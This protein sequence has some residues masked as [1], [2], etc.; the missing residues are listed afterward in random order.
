[1]SCEAK[2]YAGAMAAQELRWLTYLLTDLGEQPHSPPILYQRGLLRLAYVATRANTA[3]VFTKELPPGDYQ[4]FSTV[5]G[6]LALL[7]STGLV[8]P[9]F[10]PNLPMGG[11]APS[12]VSHVDPLPGTVP[13]EV[14]LDSGAARGAASGGAASGGAASRVAEPAGAGPEG[15]ESEGADLGG[16]EPGGAESKSAESRG[17]E[18]RGTTSSG[19]PLGAWPQLSP[20]PEPL[21]AQH[22]REWFAQ[23]TRLRSGAAGAGDSAI[24]GTGAGGT[25]ATSLGGAGVLVGA[26]GPRG[27]GAAGSGGLGA[28]GAGGAAG[29]CP[30]CYS[31]NR[32]ECA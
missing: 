5:L 3:D 4:R 22:L 21:S 6:L 28:A 9:L 11:L 8:T 20:R 29:V 32:L 14:A 16:A 13:V 23:R 10:F 2:I 27:V 1:S 17:A 30:G 25:G 12:G 19:G 31:H 7:F 18:P 24:G 15:A 26:G